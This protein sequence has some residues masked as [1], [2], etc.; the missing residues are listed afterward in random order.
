MI[1]FLASYESPLHSSGS[2]K[3]EQRFSYQTAIA[4]M[5]FSLLGWE[6][7]MALLRH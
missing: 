7:E 6:T 1:T 5:H 3:E 2:G 4:D